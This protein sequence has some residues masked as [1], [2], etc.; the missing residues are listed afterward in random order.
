MGLC[1][2][3]PGSAELFSLTWKFM[4]KKTAWIEAV[5]IRLSRPFDHSLPAEQFEAACRL[6]SRT[7]IRRAWS[8]PFSCQTIQRCAA[9][10]HVCS[11]AHPIPAVC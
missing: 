2:A 6:P 1:Q 11:M 10:K 8:V 7:S 9:C 3:F 4:M 5:R